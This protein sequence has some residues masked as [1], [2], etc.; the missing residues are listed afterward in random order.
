MILIYALG[1]ILLYLNTRNLFSFQFMFAG[2]SLPPALTSSDT[3]GWLMAIGVLFLGIGGWLY[4]FITR[5]NPKRQLERFRNAPISLGIYPKQVFMI[6]FALV[7]CVALAG[8]LFYFYK[9]GVSLFADEV[10]YARLINRHGVSGSFV[11]Q[12]LFRVFL[13]IL[14]MMYFLMGRS[15]DTKKYY[16]PLL[17]LILILTTITLLVF[18]GMRGNVVIFMFFPFLALIGLYSG[19]INLL[20]IV[21]IISGTFVSGMIVT[22]LMYPQLSF[23]ELI[24]LIFA[25]I[26]SSATDG[27]SYMA[28]VDISENGLYY[29]KTYFNDVMSLFYKLGATTEEHLTYGAS[30]A[31]RMLGDRYNGEQA[32]VYYMGELFANFGYPGL[33]IGSTFLGM[34]LQR[35]YNKILLASKDIL[36]LS[37]KI[38]FCALF[39]AI[40]GGPTLS[41]FLDYAITSSIF[42]AIFLLALFVLNVKR[43]QINSKTLIF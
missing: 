26:S 12:R 37:T 5:V 29:G 22:V 43:V 39:L 31:Q 11:Y 42:L 15:D 18:T 7:L 27:L 9:V 3:V 20:S 6:V 1:L 2:V 14:C 34:F 17:F 21:Y 19:K 40:L 25:R 30:L 16:N 33:I 8:S 32:A 10:G 4:N 13:P 24:L 28:H 23:I 35:L 36:F 38:Y 41:M